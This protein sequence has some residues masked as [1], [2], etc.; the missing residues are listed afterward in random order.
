MNAGLDFVENGSS[1]G[2]VLSGKKGVDGRVICV[3][4]SSYGGW[5]VFEEII[6]E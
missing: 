3:K 5:E 1:E 4:K 6:N 2:G